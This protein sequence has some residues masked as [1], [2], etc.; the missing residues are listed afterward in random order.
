VGFLCQECCLE[1]TLVQGL[2]EHQG[3]HKMRIFLSQGMNHS[4]AD[5]FCIKISDGIGFIGVHRSKFLDLGHVI[6]NSS[7]KGAQ[8][9]VR[10]LPDREEVIPG[11]KTR[12]RML[13]EV[14]GSK[15]GPDL[16]RVILN[17]IIVHPLLY[18]AS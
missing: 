12:H 6:L 5:K 4:H 2:E 16:D 13:L 8:G 3:G 7:N 15:G 10:L 17:S 18:R 11:I 1:L 9:L 14:Y